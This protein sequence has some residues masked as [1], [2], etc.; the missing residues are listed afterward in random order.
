MGERIGGWVGERIGGWEGERIGGRKK[1]E[2]EED[3]WK[4]RREGGGKEEIVRITA[5]VTRINNSSVRWA[6]CDK[7]TCTLPQRLF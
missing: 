6:E 3:G 1:D 2:K 5:R 4:D 7:P